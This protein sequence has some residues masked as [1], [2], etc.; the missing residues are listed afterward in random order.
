M[1]NNTKVAKILLTYGALPNSEIL[2]EAIKN[3]NI[4][5]VELLLEYRFDI[6]GVSSS[7]TTIRNLLLTYSSDQ[8]TDLS[9]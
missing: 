7:N 2:Q 6:S 8:E 3:Q 1:K 5:L 4:P 9:G